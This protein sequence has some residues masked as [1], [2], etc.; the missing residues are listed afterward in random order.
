MKL[1]GNEE[2]RLDSV[3]M[4]SERRAGQHTATG[5]RRAGYPEATFRKDRRLNIR[6]FR[7]DSSG[8]LRRATADDLGNEIIARLRVANERLDVLANVEMRPRPNV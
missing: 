4:A 5:S 8:I 2:D 1:D 6:L 7:K 3:S